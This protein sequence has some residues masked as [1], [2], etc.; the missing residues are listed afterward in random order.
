M[1]MKQSNSFPALI[2]AVI[3]AIGAAVTFGLHRVSA[4]VAAIAVLAYSVVLAYVAA[5]AIRIADQWNKAVVLRL[6][7]FRSLEGP[8]LFMI[9]PILE[10]IP[11]WID[12]RAYKLIQS[13]ED[14]HERHVS[15]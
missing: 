1:N 4:D 7:E 9:I 15:G 3:L 10:S 14:S 5:S 2:F 8:G 6:G 11:Y 13:R 12:T